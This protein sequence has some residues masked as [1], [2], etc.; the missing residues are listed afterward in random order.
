MSTIAYQEATRVSGEALLRQRHQVRRFELN[1]ALKATSAISGLHGSRFRGRGMDYAESRVYEPGDDIRNMDWRVTARTGK[2]HTKLFSE[3][4]ERPVIF[5]VDTNASMRFGTRKQFKSVAA[6]KSASL[7]GWSVVHNGDRVGLI[8]F[9]ADGVRFQKPAGGK[10]G[11]MRLIRQLVQADGS[12]VKEPDEVTTLADA[13]H[14]LRGLVRP[15]SM[16]VIL[17]DFHH[18]GENARRHLV[19][20][21]KHNDV[22][23]F[24]VSD[25]FELRAPPPGLYGVEHQ[26]RDSIF[27]ALKKKSRDAFEDM[28]RRRLGTAYRLASSAGVPL[29][30]LLTSDDLSAVISQMLKNPAAAWSR[31]LKN[32]PE[33]TGLQLD[34]PDT[35]SL[36]GQTGHGGS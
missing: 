18:P 17:S 33:L 26:G 27:N 36:A 22:L 20:L 29:I 2:P 7:L 19:Q 16:V 14:S 30:P 34:R 13:L 15:G 31:R 6:A 35:H 3:E 28:A 9:G 25:P 10:R 21:R 32:V 5:V 12:E 23:A 1:A 11:M 24:V 8:L 4:R